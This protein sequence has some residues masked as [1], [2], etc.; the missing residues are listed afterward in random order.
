[1]PQGRSDPGRG[2]SADRVRQRLGE[3]GSLAQDVAARQGEAVAHLAALY[4]ETLRR[5]G[6]LY[7]AGNGGSAADAQ[8]I[9]TE[10]VVRYGANRRAFPAVAITTDT[11]LLTACGNDLGFD[12]IF[13]RQVEALVKPGDLLILHSTSGESSNLLRAAEVA[14]ARGVRIVALL[15]KGGG[16]LRA[17]VDESLVIPS[18]ETSHIQE[19]H[20]AVEHVICEL[21]EAALLGSGRE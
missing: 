3:L 13:G 5:G 8:H 12:Q 21:V 17:L 4:V 7:F 19:L 2:V 16:R 20:L 1:M 18:R 9:A 6:T 11:S 14:R 10:Y 15:G